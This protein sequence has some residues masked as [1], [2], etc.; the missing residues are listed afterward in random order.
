MSRPWI[1]LHTTM[2]HHPGIGTLSD[3][4]FRA[5]ITM[6][7]MA[8]EGETLGIVGSRQQVRWAL[9]CT[10]ARLDAMLSELNGRILEEFGEL[11]VRDWTEWQEPTSSAE[12]TRGMRSRRQHKAQ[13]AECD[14]TV[15]SR[16]RHNAVT[17]DEQTQTQTQKQ[18][19]HGASAPRWEPVTA[20][21][22]ARFGE[23][24]TLKGQDGTRAW[25]GTL[26]RTIGPVADNDPAGAVALLDAFYRDSEREGGW[27]YVTTGNI[28]ERVGKW[29]SDK[30]RYNESGPTG[31]GAGL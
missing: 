30:K 5:W 6:L 12:R 16:E 26:C 2:L 9:R 15:T 31:L 11:S 13:V 23:P 17:C 20:W 8:A 21:C 18:Q 28:C 29:L 19:T 27:R 14:V 7:L 1:K 22:I 25:V 24:S 3:R 4:T 10:D